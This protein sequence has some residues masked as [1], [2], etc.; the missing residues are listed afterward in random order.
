MTSAGRVTAAGV[1]PGSQ[2]APSRTLEALAVGALT[3]VGLVLR[4]IRYVQLPALAD[5][6]DELAW[7]WSGLTLITRH[8]PYAWSYLPSYR[9]VEILV[10]NG[11]TYPVVHPYLDHPPLFS[12]LVGG[13]AWLQG[14][15]RITDVSPGMVRPVAI[16]L[17]AATIPLMY[18]LVRRTLSP[19]AGFLGA[20]LFA[21]APA[22]VYFGRS[23]ESENLLAP[24][25]LVALLLTVSLLRGD[26]HSRAALV[27]LAICCG[28]APLVKVPGLAVGA[29]CAAALLRGGR[30]RLSLVAIL[31]AGG[32]LA[33]YV[34][35]GYMID[36]QQFLHVFADQAA[37]REGV[38]GAYEF[39]SAPA[40]FDRALRDGWWIL[41]WIG[42]GAMMARGDERAKLLPVAGLVV[43][44]ALLVF[45]SETNTAHYGWYRI[46]IYPVVYAGAGYACWET[47]RAP[48]EGWSLAVLALGAATTVSVAL[49]YGVLHSGPPSWLIVLACASVVLPAVASR[50]VGATHRWLLPTARWSAGAM[51]AL[52]LAG[53]IVESATMTSLG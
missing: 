27:G 2:E 28:V 17:S 9:S 22:C 46:F 3:M 29:A 34:G 30:W 33:V 26:R 4:L 48:A 45:G 52:L 8:V 32:G 12:V 47:I 37:R 5:N 39:I 10:A 53:S 50:G 21:V 23:V 44:L 43:A 51:L 7:A 14:A 15:R 35:Y 40:G 38:M 20:G 19:G 16:V 42:L 18:A 49:G 41:G 13:V 6:Q 11:T 25:L 24:I 1:V 31:A 36:W